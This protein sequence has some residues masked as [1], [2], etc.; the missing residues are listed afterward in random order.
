MLSLRRNHMK[1]QDVCWIKITSKKN[2]RLIAVDFSRQKELDANPK[3]IQQV[4][5]VGQL[6]NQMTMLM[7][8]MQAIMNLCLL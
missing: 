4:E 1:I 7:L 5:F 8:Q 3:A 2:Y 6:K